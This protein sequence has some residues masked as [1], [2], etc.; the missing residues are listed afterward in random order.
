YT[1]PSNGGRGENR[2]GSQTSASNI[3][4]CRQL[5][6]PAM[7]SNIAV[8]KV[9]FVL[10]HNEHSMAHTLLLYSF[11]FDHWLYRPGSCRNHTRWGVIKPYMVNRARGTAGKRE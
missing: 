7:L 4:R 1:T 3:K 2:T 10:S 5:P 8:R 11:L 6:F 9:P